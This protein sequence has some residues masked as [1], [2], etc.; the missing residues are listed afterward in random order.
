MLARLRLSG[1]LCLIVFS[2]AAA[3]AA[4]QPS[5][6]PSFDSP[7]TTAR[8]G[9]AQLSPIPIIDAHIHLFDPTRPQGAPYSGPRPAPGTQPVAAY[10]DRYRRLAVP[11]GVVGAIKVEASP[12]IEDNLWVLEVAQRD[13]IIVGV[14]GNLEPDK[15]EFAEYRAKAREDLQEEVGIVAHLA[16]QRVAEALRAGTLEPRDALFAAD[17]ATTLYQLVTGQATT[18]TE[19]R[20]LT[21]TLDDHERETLRDAIDAYLRQPDP[22]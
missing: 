10:P 18:R 6:L 15:P 19:T 16:W 7:A 21:D 17:K 9:Q 14:V 22:A 5:S 2:S 13:P 4:D 1:V 12:W 11:L 3:N 8:S 20:E